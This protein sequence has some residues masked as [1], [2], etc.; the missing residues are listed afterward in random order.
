MLTHVY[1]C[2]CTNAHLC[3]HVFLQVIE[4]QHPEPPDGIPRRF[5]VPA[6]HYGVM[7]AGRPVRNEVSRHDFASRYNIAACDSE[8]DQVLESIVGN[9]KDSF[10][11]VRGIS[12]Y[13]N[14]MHNKEWTPYAALAAAAA[15]KAIIKSMHNPQM[16]DFWM[17]EA[18]GFWRTLHGLWMEEEWSED[19]GYGICGGFFDGSCKL[20]MWRERWTDSNRLLT[21]KGREHWMILLGSSHLLLKLMDP[22]SLIK[23]WGESDELILMDSTRLC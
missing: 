16:D 6:V 8:F 2:F 5:D 19:G 20:G 23:V 12:D 11:F 21:L 17:E 15:T 4:V 18:P 1:M 3:V 13:I 22:H 14:G 7:G 10:M 9:R